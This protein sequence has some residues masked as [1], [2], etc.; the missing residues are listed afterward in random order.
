MLGVK[1]DDHER[2]KQICAGDSEEFFE[3]VRPQ[4]D[5]LKWCGFSPLY[6]FMGAMR[7]A[8]NIQ[9]EVLRYDQW[10]IDEQ[11]VVSFAAMEFAS[12]PVA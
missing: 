1:E 3:L 12:K 5:R 11:S 6:T 10:N 4:Q 8:Q 7:N 9:G 2:L